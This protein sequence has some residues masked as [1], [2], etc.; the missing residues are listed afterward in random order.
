VVS[1]IWIIFQKKKGIILPID[2]LIF[3]KMG[4]L[5]HQPVLHSLEK[6][7]L[8]V[9]RLGTLLEAEDGL[10]TAMREAWSRSRGWCCRKIRGSKAAKT[11][12]ANDG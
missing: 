11:L 4:T 5:H 7:F 10:Q 2:E 6:S 1:N 3:F 8:E 12:W 9:N